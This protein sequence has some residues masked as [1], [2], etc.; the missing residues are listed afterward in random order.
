MTLD[1][2]LE[3][4]WW[5]AL[6][7]Q[8]LSIPGTLLPLL[9]GLLWLPLGAGIWWLGVGWHLAWPAMVFSLALFGLG[10]LADFLALGLASARLNASRWTAIGAVAGLLLGLFGLLPALPLGGPVL[11]ALFGPWLGAALVE[12]VVITKPPQNLG[13]LVAV[14]RGSVVGL[15]VVA[16]LLVSR[17]AQVL[18]ALIGVIG[19]VLITLR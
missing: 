8:L 16:G 10:L 1:W 17:L 12:A 2:N 7:V 3:W 19:F 15:A 9:P 11:G 4:F 13:W 6:L 18:L 5:L 14:R